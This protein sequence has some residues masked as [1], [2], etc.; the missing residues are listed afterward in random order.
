MKAYAEERSQTAT[1]ATVFGFASR[2]E[3]EKQPKQG[4]FL[5][6]GEELHWIFCERSCGGGRVKGGRVVH[7]NVDSHG[8]GTHR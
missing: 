5:S 1:A 2:R 8:T 7:G 4:F 6:D 3:E